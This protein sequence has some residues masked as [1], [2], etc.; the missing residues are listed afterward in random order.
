MDTPNV[1]WLVCSSDP[2]DFAL[3]IPR[4]S[5]KPSFITCGGFKPVNCVQC[6]KSNDGEWKYCSECWLALFEEDE[7]TQAASVGD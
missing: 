7:R 5:G 4:Q 3:M 1:K 2:L 6:G